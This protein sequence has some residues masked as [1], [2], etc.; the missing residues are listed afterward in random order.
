[1]GTFAAPTVLGRSREDKLQTVTFTVVGSGS[2]A[3]GG[4][5]LDLSTLGMTRID[6]VTLGATGSAVADDQYN[7]L[8]KRATAG[9]AAT[10][11]VKIRDL[12]E[13]ADAEV[14]NA[15][16]LAGVTFIGVVHGE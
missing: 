9:A 13:A 12:D 16:S 1:M 15:T 10:G 2:Y 3:T 7:C 8:Y 11:L 14:A 4:D 6:H 5:T